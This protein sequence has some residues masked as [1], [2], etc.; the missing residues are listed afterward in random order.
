VNGSLHASEL[1]AQR[2]VA[3]LRAQIS[4]FATPHRAAAERAYLKSTLV[5]LGAPVP[6]VRRVVRAWVR[7]HPSL[8]HPQLFEMAD[9]LWAAPVHE[10]RLAAV[11]L[12]VALPRL[13]RADDLAWLDVHL[14]DC[15]TWALVDPLAGVVVAELAMRERE[16]TL[17]VTE[18]WVRD[19]DFWVRRSAMLS[20]RSLLRH[21][22]ELDRC[23]AYAEVLLPEQEFFIRKAIG[24]VL[25][26]VAPRHQR[27]VSAWLR[28][29][30][31]EMNLVTLREPLR[32]LADA[33][34]LRALYDARRKPAG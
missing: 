9:A 26:E 19:A 17:A 14:R 10:L 2:E 33:D 34:E 11:E 29:H 7:R 21:G 24:W 3:L 28:E 27:E 32:K 1:D 8:T 15:R 18:R 22:D 4:E 25:R 12:L 6:D 30:M 16:P 5:H 20:L 31:A 13:V 23:F